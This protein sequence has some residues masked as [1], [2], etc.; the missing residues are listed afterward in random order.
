MREVVGGGR[1][2]RE[3]VTDT[4]AGSTVSWARCLGA[5]GPFAP[6]PSTIACSPR[7]RPPW[8]AIGVIVGSRTD[9]TRTQHWPQQAAGTSAPWHTRTT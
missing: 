6:S 9:D 5:V 8:A 7:R 3:L 4:A 1:K 2:A